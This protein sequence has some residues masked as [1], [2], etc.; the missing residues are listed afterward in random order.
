MEDGILNSKFKAFYSKI[1]FT[2]KHL[3]KRLIQSPLLLGWIIIGMII[4]IIR[5]GYKGFIITIINLILLALF[6]VI[7]KIMAD[8][9]T[10]KPISRLKHPRLELFIGILFYIFLFVE[11]AT[12]WGQAK[13]PYISSKISHLISIIGENI[14]KLGDIGIPQWLLNPLANA[15]ISIAFELIPII[16]LFVIFGYGFKNMGFVFSN[17][18]LILI[19]LGITI[20]LGLPFK[21]LFQ[22][23]F[24][25]TILTFFIQV[26]INGLPE[27]LVFRG[28]LLPR[29]ETVLKNP[30]NALVFV[31]ILFNMSHIP[32]YMAHGMSVYQALLST[33]SIIFPSGLIWGYL[34]LKTRSIVPGVIWHTST[35]FLGMTFIGF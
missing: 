3:L 33:F 15:S 6:T 30:I 1:M 16:I 26:F 13:I 29:F 5:S 12:F 19:L 10:A 7:I 28:Y 24:N 25:K 11:L 20:V 9:S 18:P 31:A 34:Y 21:I 8:N 4:E 35:S 17:L 14:S 2:I 22:Q 27:E 32:S 23:P